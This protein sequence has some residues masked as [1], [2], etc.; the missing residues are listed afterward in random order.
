MYAIVKTGGKQYKVKPG[1]KFTV[2]KLEGEKG[3]SIKL[4]EVLFISEENDSEPMIG[5]PLVDGAKVECEVV[6]QAKSKKTIVFKF[7]KRK[8]YM[9][10]KGHRQ[11]LTMLKVK[12]VVCGSKTWKAE[13]TEETK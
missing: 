4:E 11:E 12:N 10:N 5:K 13:K 2:E 8:R 7:K 3:S 6:A 9:R 1:D